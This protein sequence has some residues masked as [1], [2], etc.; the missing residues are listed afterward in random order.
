MTQL[1]ETQRKQIQNEFRKSWDGAE[2]LFSN[3]PDQL[4]K[5]IK[6]MRVKGYDTKLR[7]GAQLT[8]SFIVSRSY[9]HFLRRGQSSIKFTKLQEGMRVTYTGCY[10]DWYDNVTLEF[11]TIHYNEKIDNLVQ[12]LLAHD[13]S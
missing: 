10:L 1:T 4:Q 8:M 13:I 7:A 9:Y 11:D 3:P 6:A 12:R 5:I 2:E